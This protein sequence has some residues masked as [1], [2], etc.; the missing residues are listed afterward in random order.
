MLHRLSH[1]ILRAAFCFYLVSETW[2]ICPE[3]QT[4]SGGARWHGRQ[5]RGPHIVQHSECVWWTK[6]LSLCQNVMMRCMWW[7]RWMK[8]WSWED[9]DTIQLTLRPQ[10]LGSTG[11]L[12]NGKFPPQDRPPTSAVASSK[13]DL[14]SQPSTPNTTCRHRTP[15]GWGNKQTD[16]FLVCRLHEAMETLRQALRNH[17]GAELSPL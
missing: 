16:S 1:L 11:A 9:Y 13:T 12:L 8:R 2:V 10:C 6:F 4:V 7:E 14:S 17:C 15:R 3:L 5:S